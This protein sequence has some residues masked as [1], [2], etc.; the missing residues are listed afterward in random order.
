ME[1]SSIERRTRQPP[2][3]SPDR[4]APTTTTGA[5]RGASTDVLPYHLDRELEDIE[6]IISEA[7]GPAPLYGVSSGGALAL[8]AAAAGLAVDRVAVY[9]VPYCTAGAMPQRWLNY[10]DDLAA[11]LGKGESG[12]AIALFMRLV[13]TP[14][15][16]IA[17]MREAPFWP[18]LESI[19]HTLAY[20]AACLGD[21]QPPVARLQQI[22]SPT[23]VLTGSSG[24][25]T[26]SGGLPADFYED[27]ARQIAAA[28]PHA[29]RQTLD[30]QAHVADPEVVGAALKLF[31]RDR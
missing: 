27:P 1:D 31:F 26:E 24:P 17:S 28:I 8:E 19:A 30:G 10:I 29:E 2:R 6:A 23:L 14:D 4:S 5:G 21:G 9:E 15:E 22:T 12:D 13:G 11:A 3:R 18:A 7:G 25:G 20:E 16:V